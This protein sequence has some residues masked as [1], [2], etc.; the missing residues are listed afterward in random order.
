M[1]SDPKTWVDRY[2]DV[3]YRY[4]LSRVR[5]A[6]TAEELVQ[7]TLVTALRARSGFAGRSS[8]QTWLISILR[9]K[10][11][12][13][14]RALARNRQVPLD[15]NSG[16]TDDPHFDHSHRW[17]DAVPR[18]PTGSRASMETREF[19]QVLQDCMAKLPKKLSAAFCLRELE[20]LDTEKTCKILGI[21]ASN[22][23]MQLHRA[24]MQLRTCLERNW[25]MG[26]TRGESS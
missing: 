12:D 6:E 23:W 26:R 7:E 16:G 22:L 4:A 10:I 1:L 21:T 15:E 9:N 17:K 8:E 25:F 3:L 18:W 5:V 20:Q 13:H 19:R 2:G 24:R 14:Y 11:A